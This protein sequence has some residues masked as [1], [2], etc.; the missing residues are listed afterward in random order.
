MPI[1]SYL[2][3]PR[4]GAKELLSTALARLPHCTVVPA[5]NHDVVVLVTDT[6][7]Q[8][9]EEALQKELQALPLLQSL[10]LVFGYDQPTERT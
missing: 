1:F 3:I 4:T 5:D 6:P 10:S 7:D 8:S 9:A 2:A